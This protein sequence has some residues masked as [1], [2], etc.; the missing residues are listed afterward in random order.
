MRITA[1][2]YSHPLI[3]SEVIHNYTYNLIK[4]FSINTESILLYFRT[5]VQKSYNHNYKPLLQF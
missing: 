1:L 4:C 3:K 2:Q 5:K